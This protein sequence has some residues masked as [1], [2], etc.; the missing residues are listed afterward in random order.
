MSACKR[1]AKSQRKG[2]F[3]LGVD[4]GGT[5]TICAVADPDGNIVGV[6]H[7]G[8]TNFQA[9]GIVA[10]GLEA[11]KAI[12]SAIKAAGITHEQ[13]SYAAYG[14]AGADREEDFDIVVDYFRPNNPAGMWLLCNDT[15]IA[16]R[17]GTNDGIGLAMICGSGSNCIGF[18]NE[19]N[20]AKVGG[21]GNFSGDIGYGEN[22]VEQALTECTKSKD[23]RGPKTM[24]YDEFCKALGVKSLEDIIQFWYPDSYKPPVLKTYA[25][26]VFKCAK[27]GDKVAVKLLTRIADELGSNAVTALRRLFKKDDKVKVVFGGSILQHSDPP[28]YAERIKA[29]VLKHY[30]NATIVR[31]KD[32]P[33]VGAVLFALDLMH[34]KAGRTRQ[35]NVKR[36]YKEA[37][38]IGTRG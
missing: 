15:T 9:V 6:G 29:K 34:G 31:L 26:L 7:S 30:P 19:G 17:A 10:A 27:A 3:V 33:V 28:I 38:Q 20:Q 13:I 12:D 5:K 32:E 37:K 1:K 14:V 24:M 4:G 16:L 25:P 23:G 2:D 18:N 21:F 36:S 11:Q 22:L 8:P 35:A